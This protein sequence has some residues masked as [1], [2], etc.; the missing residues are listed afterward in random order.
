MNDGKYKSESVKIMHCL[1]KSMEEIRF[2]H[3]GN[4][5][6]TIACLAMLLHSTFSTDFIDRT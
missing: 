2:N 4:V 1:R 6:T 5:F 3:E